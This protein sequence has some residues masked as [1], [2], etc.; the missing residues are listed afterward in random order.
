M[1]FVVAIMLAGIIG[2]LIGTNVTRNFVL[3]A[4]SHAAA[5]KSV[6][7]SLSLPRMPLEAAGAENGDK[8]ITVSEKSL[9]GKDLTGWK[10]TRGAWHVDSKD[11]LY[12]DPSPD[13][14]SRIETAGSYNDFT[15]SGKVFIDKVR[16][17]EIQFHGL[18]FGF[19]YPEMGIWSDLEV[20]SQGDNVKVTV[21]GAPAKLDPPNA[22]PTEPKSPIGF[23]VMKGGQMKLKDLKLKQTVTAE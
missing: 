7:A 16:Y 9:I 12:N 23:F 11:E 1:L 14:Y 15:L 21:N 18:T 5:M 2:Y 8:P 3:P 20:V 22:K 13:S 4:A 17:G 19:E 6:P 10:P